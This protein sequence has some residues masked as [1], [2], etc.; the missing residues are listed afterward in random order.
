MTGLKAGDQCGQ[1]TAYQSCIVIWGCWYPNSRGHSSCHTALSVLACPCWDPVITL[2]S[3]FLTPNVVMPLHGSLLTFV[4]KPFIK[5]SLL[6]Q[7]SAS[8]YLDG[9]KYPINRENSNH[10]NDFAGPANKKNSVKSL[11]IFPRF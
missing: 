3:H 8:S 9:D 6:T 10:H 4:D 7:V 5:H 1:V 2:S 11:V